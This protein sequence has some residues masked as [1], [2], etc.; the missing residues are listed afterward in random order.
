MKMIE[1]RIGRTARSRAFTLVEMLLVL[2]ILAILA[3]IVLPKMIGRGEEA[4]KKATIAQLAAFAQAL[5]LFEV[6]NGD[7]P[8]GRNGLNDLK[9]Q[10]RD[11]RNWH[12]YLDSIPLD[13]WGHPYIYV[14][15]GK[16]RPTSYDLS[17]IGPDGR[18]GT[19][20][21]ITNWQQQR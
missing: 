1:S 5:D 11:A 15:P 4:K 20:D 8:S 2:T 17:S 13:Q 3:G 7:Y 9:E 12:Q 21:D 18:E 14:K 6:D 10:P 19:E 16:H